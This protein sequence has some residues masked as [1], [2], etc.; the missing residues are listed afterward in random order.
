MYNITCLVCK[1]P[2]TTSSI[3]YTI[4]SNALLVLTVN[5]IPLIVQWV[6]STDLSVWNVMSMTS[7]Y[8]I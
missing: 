4:S 6:R 8:G 2:L 7:N 1:I 5:L 3:N